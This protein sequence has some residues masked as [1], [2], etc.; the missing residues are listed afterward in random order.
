MLYLIKLTRVNIMKLLSN[1]S[2]K[3]RYNNTKQNSKCSKKSLYF[4]FLS[5][6]PN[7]QIHVLIIR[8]ED[9]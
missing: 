9:A 2:C 6:Y 7:K 8:M 5:F 3:T 1:I 4:Y